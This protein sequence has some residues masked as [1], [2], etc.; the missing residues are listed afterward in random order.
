MSGYLTGKQTCICRLLALIFLIGLLSL[1]TSDTASAATT[2]AISAAKAELQALSNLVDRLSTE[3]ERVAEDYNYANQQYEDAKTGADKAAAAVAQA[4]VDL[5]NARDRLAE[6]LVDIYKSGNMTTLNALL[7]SDSFADVL[8]LI[9][10]FQSIAQED[11]RLVDEIRGYRDKQAKMQ[12]KLEASLAQLEEYR[13]QTAAAKEKVLAQLQKQKKALKGKE[14]QLAQLRK[15]EAAR[16]AKLAAELRAYK[17]FLK[18]RPG[19]VIAEAKKYLG[20]HYVWAGSS[21]SGFDCSGLVM[22]VYAKVGVKLPH[23][24]Y[25]QFRLGTPVSRAN[26]KPGDLVFFFTPIAHVGIYVG[27][28]KMINATGF[29]VQISEVWPR[30]FRGGRRLL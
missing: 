24:S 5:A 2:P 29:H 27:D 20:V 8:T 26:L 6:R 12:A 28:G 13:N 19:K 3:L 30:S 21:P 11:S 16:Q 4:E 23:S 7:G 22:Y 17:A 18:T 10:E 25:L 1:T 15:A 9:D 14:A